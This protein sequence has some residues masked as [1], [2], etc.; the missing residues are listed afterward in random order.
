MG[1]V[2][3]REGCSLGHTGMRRLPLEALDAT[4]LDATTRLHV[5]ACAQQRRNLVRLPSRSK[6]SHSKYRHSKYS[7]SKGSVSKGSHSK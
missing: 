1:V 2:L 5:A 3:Q 4:H 6:H 7:H